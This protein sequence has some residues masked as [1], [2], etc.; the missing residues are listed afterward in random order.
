MFPEVD[1]SLKFK[2]SEIQ[3]FRISEIQKL[4]TQKIQLYNKFSSF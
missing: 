4:E 2:N 3:N 1:K